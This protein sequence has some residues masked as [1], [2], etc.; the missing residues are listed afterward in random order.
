ME[1]FVEGFEAVAFVADAAFGEDVVGFVFLRVGGGAVGGVAFVFTHVFGFVPLAAGEHQQSFG[2]FVI[3]GKGGRCAVAAVAAAPAVF[4]ADVAAFFGIDEI[5]RRV[6]NHVDHAAEGVAAVEGGV[7]AFDDVD[8]PEGV[9]FDHVAAGHCAVGAAAFVG[10]GHAHAVHHHQDAVAADAAY[11]KTGMATPAVV[12]GD[13]HA[14]L[15][16]GDVVDVGRCGLVEG[17]AADNGDV[18]R[19][20]VEG[21]RVAVGGY[22]HG[23]QGVGLGGFGGVKGGGKQRGNGAGKQGGFHFADSSNDE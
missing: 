20:F 15:V 21:L 1:A 8:L 19:G 12:G 18:G 23:F 5:A 13:F 2:V 4:E 14:R 7:G 9:G 6:G 22:D 10:F 17:F 11:G 16:E 3:A